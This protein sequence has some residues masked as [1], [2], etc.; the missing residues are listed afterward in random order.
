MT[1]DFDIHPSLIVACFVMLGITISTA[2]VMEKFRFSTALDTTKLEAEDLL[3]RRAAGAL[4]PWIEV[5]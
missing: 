1:N 5:K 4:R 2:V 3:H